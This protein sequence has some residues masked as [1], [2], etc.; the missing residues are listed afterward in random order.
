MSKVFLRTFKIPK[1]LN[2]SVTETSKTVVDAQ[3]VRSKRLVI[4]QAMEQLFSK[5]DLRA[6]IK[7]LLAST[8]KQNSGCMPKVSDSNRQ[9]VEVAFA[10]KKAREGTLKT[11]KSMREA[12]P[13]VVHQYH[14]V[15]AALYLWVSGAAEIEFK[16]TGE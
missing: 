16:P 12:L 13:G 15:G 9:F 2:A 4:G 8:I 10:T 5:K 1:N 7:K 11:I 14:V 6:Q 3:G